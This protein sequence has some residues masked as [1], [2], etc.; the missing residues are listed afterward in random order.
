M[1]ECRGPFLKQKEP[2]LGK[3]YDTPYFGIGSVIRISGTVGEGSH[4]VSVVTTGEDQAAPILTLN[5]S[6]LGINIDS[7][8]LKYNDLTA[9]PLPG[10]TPFTII[11]DINSQG[12]SMDIH[13]DQGVGSL[14]VEYGNREEAWSVLSKGSRVKVEASGNVTVGMLWVYVLV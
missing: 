3:W 14:F 1:A 9:E 10:P 7:S 6:Q 8:V 5:L 12:I 2:A 11:V 4:E 13:T